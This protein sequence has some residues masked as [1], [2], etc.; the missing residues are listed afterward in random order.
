MDK[1]FNFSDNSLVKN[2]ALLLILLSG[3]ALADTVFGYCSST[4]YLLPRQLARTQTIS[5]CFKASSVLQNDAGNIALSYCRTNWAESMGLTIEARKPNVAAEAVYM[6]EEGRPFTTEI[7]CT[8]HHREYSDR[9]L[10]NS[11]TH[12]RVGR[13]GPVVSLFNG[14]VLSKVTSLWFSSVRFFCLSEKCL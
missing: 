13:P 8:R 10:A 11:N 4:W 1:D 3:H 6:D 12:S 5:S 2:I 14:I 9:Y 7:E